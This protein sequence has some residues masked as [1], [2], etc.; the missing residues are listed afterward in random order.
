MENIGFKPTT[1]DPSVFINEQGI[2]A[3][4]YVDDILI[5][6]LNEEAINPTKQKLQSFH[7]MKDSGL[8]TKILGIR[9]TWEKN[10]I[11]LDQ[12]AYSEEILIEFGMDNSKMAAVPL[13]SSVSLLQ[14]SPKLSEDEHNLY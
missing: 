14:D 9:I 13:S 3:A 4:I 7:M 12:K 10:R 8:V 11:L 6:G 2:I 1:T 5:F